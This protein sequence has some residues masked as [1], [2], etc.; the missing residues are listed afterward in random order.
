MS[1]EMGI[2]EDS[3]ATLAPSTH[4]LMILSV[5]WLYLNKHLKNINFVNKFTH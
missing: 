1:Y 3:K 4:C 5:K 2:R